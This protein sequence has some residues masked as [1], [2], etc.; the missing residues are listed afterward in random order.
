MNFFLRLMFMI[1][2]YSAADEFLGVKYSLPRIFMYSFQDLASKLKQ[3]L[4]SVK[5]L[6]DD[7]G[8]YLSSSGQARVHFASDY[9]MDPATFLSCFKTVV[10]R[11]NKEGKEEGTM[12]G[13][14]TEEKQEENEEEEVTAPTE[15]LKMKVTFKENLAEE[16]RLTLGTKCVILDI[17]G[18]LN[19][20]SLLSMNEIECYA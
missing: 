2:L 1:N 7:L 15:E 16:K 19:V 5:S 10:Q 20:Y 18:A 17:S 4:T 14:E 12:Q 3:D 9:S 11:A 8:S 6:L 13:D